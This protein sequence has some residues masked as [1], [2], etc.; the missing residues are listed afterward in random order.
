VVR[1]T[2]QTAW[3][4]G[5]GDLLGCR[6]GALVEVQPPQ[7][8]RGDER[9]DEPSHPGRGGR[10]HRGQ[11]GADN[12]D[13][14]AQCDQDERLTPLGEVAALDR[15]VRGAGAAKPGGREAGQ[16]AGHVDADR[17]QPQQFPGQTVHHTTD[18]GECAADQAPY[19][20]APEVGLQRMPAQRDHH[21]HGPAG[22]LDRVRT[23]DPQPQ[24]FERPGQRG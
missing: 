14:L 9:D 21:E 4:I 2:A 7:G 23:A 1:G 15:P 11:R 22:L 19:Q 6:L 12:D 10:I 20:D 16:A 17:G 18:D 3:V 24:V 13:R 8:D 5:S